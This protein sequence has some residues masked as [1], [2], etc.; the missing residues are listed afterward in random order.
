MAPDAAASYRL[1]LVLI[2]LST[3]SWSTTGLFTRIL[4]LDGWTMLAWRSLFGGL[5]LLVIILALEGRAGL[6]RFR[7]LGLQGAA[8]VLVSGV[9]MA[10]Y[11]T[12]MVHTTVAHVAV[13][14]AAAP[15]AAA[16]LGWLVL[17]ERPARSALL[18]A[19]AALGGVAVMVGL[20]PEGHWSG[21][22]IAVVMTLCMAGLMVL[23][24][25]FP[26]IPTLQAAC[27]SALLTA[28]LCVPLGRPLE[29]TGGDLWVLLL[30][31]LMSNAAG[32]GLFILGARRLPPVET[33][34]V[35]A[36]EAPLAPVWVWIAFAETPSAAT[37]LGGGVV[38]AAVVWHILAGARRLSGARNALPG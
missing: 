12:A 3:V 13:I 36:L 4:A 18:A 15:F 14:Y 34:L 8:Y 10:T 23:A 1:G 7:R 27:L 29:V 19:G 5:G 20:G 37:M 2:L 21:D 9:G 25:R 31:G 33:A 38:M 11:L 17:R 30:F 24:R 26:Q 6:V 22:L 32:L 16:G 28:V 35:S